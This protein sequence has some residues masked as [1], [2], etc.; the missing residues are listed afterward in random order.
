M[1][2]N[3]YIYNEDFETPHSI[4]PMP[5]EPPTY[6][7]IDHCTICGNTIRNTETGFDEAKACFECRQEVCPDCGV[8]V[9]DYTNESFFICKRCLK[10]NKR[11]VK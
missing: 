3:D 2:Y 1:G 4:S 5:T 6:F 8:Y 9:T 7:Y 10:N 11:P